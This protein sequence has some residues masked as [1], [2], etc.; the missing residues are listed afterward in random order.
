MPYP[1]FSER[2]PDLA[3]EESLRVRKIDSCL[4]CPF[5]EHSVKSFVYAGQPEN[6]I[7]SASQKRKRW[8]LLLVVFSLSERLHMPPSSLKAAENGLTERCHASCCSFETSIL[9]SFALTSQP[10][11]HERYLARCLHIFVDTKSRIFTSVPLSSM[12]QKAPPVK[13]QKQSLCRIS[14][15][16]RESVDEDIF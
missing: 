10:R 13:K 1:S 6:E 8:C 3:L 5:R 7:R 4:R 15:I 14:D 9:F 16:R 2:S 12:L 11:T